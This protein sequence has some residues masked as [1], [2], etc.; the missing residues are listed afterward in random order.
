MKYY[1]RGNGVIEGTPQE[2]AEYIKLTTGKVKSSVISPRPGNTGTRR[3]HY[4]NA[5]NRSILKGVRE[6][7]TNVQISR[8]LKKLGL[9]PH[10]R[11]SKAIEV[12]I[13][14]LAKQ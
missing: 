10:K 12:Q 5:E 4:S 7:K 6:G 11:T 2:V 8:R 13:G 1:S 9:S 14:R 3:A